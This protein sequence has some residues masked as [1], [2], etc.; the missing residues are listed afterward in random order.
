MSSAGGKTTP[1]T[2]T[3]PSHQAESDRYP[4]FLPDGLHFLYTKQASMPDESGVY[5]G[6]LDGKTN[7]PL[8]H[9][10]TSAVYIPPRY[11]LFVDG[12]TLLAYAF[13]GERLEVKD[14]P[15]VLAEHVGRRS[16]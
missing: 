12:E 6:S 7:K 2:I 15:F 4:Y 5:A 8:L 13:D 9:I 1:V 11:L 14:Q 10:Y 16:S 3:N